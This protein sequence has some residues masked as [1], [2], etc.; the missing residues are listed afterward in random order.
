M[1]LPVLVLLAMS[2]SALAAEPQVSMELPRDHGWWIGDVLVAAAVI[3]VDEAYEL[4]PASLPNPRA[5]TYWLDLRTVGVTDQGSLDGR[6]TYVIDFEYQTFYAPLE[7]KRL[8]VPAVTIGF[9][10]GERHVTATV[11]PW[12]FVSSP[13]REILAPTVPEAIRDAPRPSVVDTIGLQLRAAASLAV[14]TLSAAAFAWHRNLWPFRRK[15]RPFTDAFGEVR[16]LLHRGADDLRYRRALVALHRGFDRAFGRRM[17]APDV[18]AFL[19]S[20]PIFAA[21]AERIF[22]FFEASRHAFFGP[23]AGAAET[24][25]PPDELKRFARAL[26]EIERRRP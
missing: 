18:E 25:L 12:S 20:R 22:A 11:P 10:S 9:R 19:R 6:R 8:V 17:L 13:L 21:H 1:M 7:P 26:A 16:R 2:G 24:L 15:D 5:V 4:D 3:R 23:D 14:A